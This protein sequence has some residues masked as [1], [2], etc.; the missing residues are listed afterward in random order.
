MNSKKIIV[1]TASFA[2]LGIAIGSAIYFNTADDNK[3][4]EEHHEEAP[5]EAEEKTAKIVLS[6]EQQQKMN[7]DIRTASPGQLN[8]IVTTRGK[9]IPHPDGLVHIL[10]KAPGSVREALKNVGDSVKAGESLAVLESQEMALMKADY[11]AAQS[12]ERLALSVFD[13][14]E[15]LHKKQITSEQDF[16]NAKANYE[17]AKINSNLARQKLYTFGLCDPEINSLSNQREPDFRFYSVCSPIDGVVTH[18]HL[19]K[20]EY[21]ENTATIFEIADFST[22]WIDIAIYPKD[23]SKIKQGQLVDITLPGENTKSKARIVFIRPIIEGE[24]ITAQAYAEMDNP[25]RNWYAG[26]FVN[27][28]VIADTIP[29][30]L[31]IS[32]DALQNIEGQNCV[33]LCTA[34]GFEKRPVKIGRADRENVEIL[35]G[36]KPGDQ[37]ANQ[38][39]LLKAELGKN[40]VEED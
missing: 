27:V 16:L 5:A 32:N 35:S 1:N 4:L 20:G 36:I 6:E 37:Y 8:L 30:P 23:L 33:F 38:A 40:S 3:P 34:E 15:T 18:R 10:P 17:E 14:E 13:R 2:L 31:V 19:T 28:D 22:L 9:V 25:S 29:L 24:T 12:K 11:L 39:F 26:S 21:V 7:L